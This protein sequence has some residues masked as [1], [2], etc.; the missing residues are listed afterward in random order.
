MIP[1]L[2]FVFLLCAVVAGGAAAQKEMSARC[3]LTYNESVRASG[4]CTVLSEPPVVAV[5]VVAEKS[6][7]DYLVL[8]DNK[9]EEGILI[10]A[11]TLTLADGKLSST[12]EGRVQWP[13]G[14]VL[15][16]EAE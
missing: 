4:S 1:I 7:K 13:N 8:I 16:I 9:K 5:K 10:E 2:P 11:G 3:T 14:Y 15:T 6:G 12:R